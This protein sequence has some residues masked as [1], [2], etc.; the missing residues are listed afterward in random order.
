MPV[1]ADMWP[2]GHKC[3]LLANK[4]IN[5]K[6]LYDCRHQTGCSHTKISIRPELAYMTQSYTCGPRS[7]CYCCFA[8]LV[9]IK[10]YTGVNTLHYNI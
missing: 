4:E 10:F 5:I 8:L 3:L 9:K 6:M 1:F 7:E 2:F